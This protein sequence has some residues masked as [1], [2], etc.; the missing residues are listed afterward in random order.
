MDD[1]V[2]KP[3]SLADIAAALAVTRRRVE[4]GD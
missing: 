3:V 4:A 1:H 2:P